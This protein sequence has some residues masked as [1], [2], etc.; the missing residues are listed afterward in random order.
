[1]A[2]A[3]SSAGAARAGGLFSSIRKLVA[4]LVAVVST[5]LELLANEIHAEGRRLARMLVLGAAALFFLACSVLLFTF[6]LIAAFWDTHRLLAIGGCAVFY[7]LIGVTLA[8]LARVHA[9][10]GT[11][12]FEASLGELRKDRDR[13]SA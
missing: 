12:L 4:T 7:L 9:G 3:D 13:L 1:M 11:R 8:A 5:R 2:G 6:L 10:A